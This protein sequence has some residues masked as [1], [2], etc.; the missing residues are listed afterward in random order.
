MNS[1]VKHIVKTAEINNIIN[2]LNSIPQST[3]E[4]NNSVATIKNFLLWKQ[5]KAPK[6][7]KSPYV[8]DLNNI[9]KY[10]NKQIAQEISKL[11]ELNLDDKALDYFD[12]QNTETT[13]IN[14]LSKLNHPQYNDS[15]NT[16]KNYISWKAGKLSEKQKTPNLIDINKLFYVINDI[17][18][19]KQ[20]AKL[21][22]IELGDQ[23]I[24]YFSLLK[25]ESKA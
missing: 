24:N 6:P 16:I 7:Q 10:I 9:Y 18:T 2:I 20:I 22:D 13:I 15:I 23:L 12:L 17:N 25:S 4:V 19:I 8:K 14:Y 5:N 1:L 21:V 3:E 11:C